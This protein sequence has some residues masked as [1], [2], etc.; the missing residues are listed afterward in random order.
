MSDKIPEELRIAYENKR[1]QL[2]HISNDLHEIFSLFL[3]EGH[4]EFL[5]Y[6]ECDESDPL[7]IEKI[8]PSPD[9]E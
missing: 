5:P 7:F 3:T 4:F 2:Q 6:D 1:R 9:G 8:S